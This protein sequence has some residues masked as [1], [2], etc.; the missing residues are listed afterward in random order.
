MPTFQATVTVLGLLLMLGAL[1]SGLA[2]RSM[3]SLAAL[4]VLAG[5]A[6]GHG[7]LDVVDF[8]ARSAFVEDLAFAA[9]IV[10][11]FRDGLEV[12]GEMLQRAWHLPLRKLVLA[13][14]LTTIIVAAAARLLVGLSWTE[15]F[16]LGA[17]LAPT[18][19]VL[20][21]SIVTNPRVPRLV[22]HSLNLESGLNDGLALP[23]V[24]AFAAALSADSDNFVWWRF[25]LQ[26]IGLG[27]LYG[28]ACGW[29]A[30]LLMP[31]AKGRDEGGRPADERIPTHQRS[32]FALGVAFATY[33]VTVISPKGNGFIA[34]F[35]AAIVLSVRRPDVREHFERNSE[36]I[37]EIVKLG[38]F[39][40]F[41]SLLTVHAFTSEGWVALPFVAVTFLLARPLAVWIALIGTR[42]DTATR[43]FMGWFGPKGVASMTFALIVLDRQIPGGVRIFNLTA[44]V[45]FCSIILHGITD[46]PGANW[47]ARRAERVGGA[48]DLEEPAGGDGAASA[49]A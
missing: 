29:I 34:V 6:L 13:M 27:F 44:L 3:L 39:L 18:D 15:S 40:V 26:D 38:I 28:I 43:L 30:S 16:L 5:F 48:T 21:S 8:R 45:V 49:Q 47:I 41:G 33:G 11:L 25:V 42:T 32:L 37:V 31:R 19:P 2:R 46:T 14:P 12:E 10:I 35:V 36:E 4:F 22:R 20:T 1:V 9:L 7:G 24:L 17:L 23:A